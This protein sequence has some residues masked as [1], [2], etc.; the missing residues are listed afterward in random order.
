MLFIPI[1]YILNLSSFLLVCKISLDTN[2]RNKNL[3]LLYNILIIIVLIIEDDY[4][5]PLSSTIKI[6]NI[7]LQLICD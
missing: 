2:G 3:L 6:K 4:N 5:S 1:W 7:N